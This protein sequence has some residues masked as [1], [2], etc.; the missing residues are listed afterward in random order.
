MTTRILIVDD[1]KW[2]CDLVKRYLEQDGYE[3]QM[4][5]DGEK[6]LASFDSFHPDL[7]I[8]DWMLPKL[9]GLEVARQV[10]TKSNIPIIMLT[11]RADEMDRIEGLNCGADDYVVKPFSARELE[12]RVRA[13]LRRTRG[14][15]QEQ[16]PLE[17]GEI[18]LDPA[19][20]EVK[21]RGELVE[22]TPMEFDLLA[23][24]L[25]HPGRVFTRLELLEAVRGTT[26]DSFARSIDSHIKRLRAKIEA[27]SS[28]PQYIQTVFG[29]GYKL[30]GNT[31]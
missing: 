13:V 25:S 31:G 2:V 14:E 18:Y 8:L 4:A 11:A 3:V 29:I 6:A 15:S 1:E 16:M 10:R 17:F 7:I 28:S 22:L 26:Y 30:A 21:I 20:H 19:C 24:L 27:D 9:D 5:T 12:V 23:F